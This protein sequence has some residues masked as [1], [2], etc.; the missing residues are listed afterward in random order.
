MT[1]RSEAHFTGAVKGFGSLLLTTYSLLPTVI[2]PSGLCPFLPTPYYLL[3]T[4]PAAAV[5]R[6]CMGF[7]RTMR[8]GSRMIFQAKASKDKPGAGMAIDRCRCG[9]MAAFDRRVSASVAMMSPWFSRLPG[10]T[11]S[12]GSVCA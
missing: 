3:P 12:K 5:L 10:A 9:R 1:M 7:R 8:S 2:P 4:G 11:S 6:M